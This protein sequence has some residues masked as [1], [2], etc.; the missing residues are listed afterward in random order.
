MVLP[1][2]REAVA[3]LR[4]MIA[5]MEPTR[6]IFRSNHASNSLPL[7]G[8]LPKDKQR[9]LDVLDAVVADESIPLRAP[10]SPHRL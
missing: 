2:P 7:A 6:A 5:H 4:T 8:N 1:G 10:P 9:I 3:E